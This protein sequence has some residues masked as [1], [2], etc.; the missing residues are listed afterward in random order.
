MLT[1]SSN[2]GAKEFQNL[3]NT[4]GE[5]LY[6]TLAKKLIIWASNSKG[7][8]GSIVGATS[9]PELGKIL[10]TFKKSPSIEIP[11]LIPGVG[12]QGGS[13]SDTAEVLKSAGYNLTIVRINSSSGLNYAYERF[14]SE[15]FAGSTVR[16]LKELNREIGFK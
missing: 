12:A 6:I 16:A 4:S 3:R 2:P 8:L 10:G 13:A 5:P 11:L 1:R 7:N 9:L 15:D 14:E